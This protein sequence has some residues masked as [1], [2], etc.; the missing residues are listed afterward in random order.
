MIEKIG[1]NYTV[2]CGTRNFSASFRNGLDTECART[3]FA[4]LAGQQ[5]RE[6]P[7]RAASITLDSAAGAVWKKAD[8]LPVQLPLLLLNF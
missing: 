3:C 1:M 8:N 2:S 6:Q 7:E 4:K 5:G